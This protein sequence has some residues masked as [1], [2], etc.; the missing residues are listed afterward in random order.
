[1]ELPEYVSNKLL[2][3]FL[4]GD[5][6]NKYTVFFKIKR[7]E[8]VLSTSSSYFTLVDQPYREFMMMLVT[9]LEPN[10]DKRRT[11][12]LNELEAVDQVTFVLSGKV[13]LGYEINNEKRYAI[14]YKDK[15]IIGAYNCTFNNR[16]D[17]IYTALTDVDSYFIRKEKWRK[18][19]K[20]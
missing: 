8:G 15:C 16:S 13:V 3:G 14:R 19:L 2:I 10:K 18:I 7:G 9:S 11:I 12:L 1:M 20:M 4:F 5:F 17:Y 6:V